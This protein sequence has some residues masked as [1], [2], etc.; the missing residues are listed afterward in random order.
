MIFGI[1]YLA[2]QSFPYI[3]VVNHGFD[4]QSTG[5]AFIGLGIGMLMGT[6]T[7]IALIM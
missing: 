7:N 5:L 3:F 1:L 2:F 6:A 4:I